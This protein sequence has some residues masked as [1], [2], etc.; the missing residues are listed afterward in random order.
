MLRSCPGRVADGKHKV[1]ADVR[2]GEAERIPIPKVEN[3]LL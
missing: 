2:V 3:A 1:E